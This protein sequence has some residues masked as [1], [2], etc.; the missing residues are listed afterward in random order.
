MIPARDGSSLARNQPLG[1]VGAC[2]SSSTSFG[3]RGYVAFPSV[4][5]AL[6]DAAIRVDQTY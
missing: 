4:P 3:V 5:P 1:I 6:A 2:R